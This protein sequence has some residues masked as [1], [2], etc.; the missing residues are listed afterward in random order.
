M[1]FSVF[2]LALSLASF[3]ELLS[4][5]S[6]EDVEGGRF[7]EWNKSDFRTGGKTLIGEGGG[8]TGNRFAI[9]RSD[10]DTERSAWIQRKLLPEGAIAVEVGGWYR[11]SP[12][13]K[14]ERYKGASLRV[15]WFN[16]ANGE[17]ALTQKFYPVS[18]AWRE[19]KDELFMAPAGAV[20]VELQVFHWLTPGETHW[21]DVSVKAIGKEDLGN[22]PERIK[23]VYG[24]DREPVFGTNL[25]YSPEHGEVVSMNPPPFRWL[26]IAGTQAYRLQICRKADF[27]DSSLI[28]R[29]DYPWLVEVPYEPLE[30]GEWHWRYGVEVDSLGCLWSKTR[31]FT[32][33]ADAKVWP[34]PKADKFQVSAARPRLF[35]THEG[36]PKLRERALNGNLKASAESLV[37][38]VQKYAGEELVAEPDFLPA[39]RDLRSQAYTAIFRATRPPM[40]KMQ[41]A[42]QAYLLT[43]DPVAG[44]E[45]K[46]RV[47]H[48]FG[49]DPKGSTNTFHNDEPA[50]WVMMRGCR[51]YDWTYEL[52][53][54]EER[55]KVE[56]SMT[57]RARDI[58]R[59]LRRKP[60]DNNP[61]ESHAGRQIGFLGEAAI[62][63]YHEVPDEAKEWLQ[64]I[65]RI[66]WG[67]YPAWGGEDGGWNEG[68]H[69]WSAYM[70]FALHFVLALRE[71]TGIDISR[72]PFFANT[73]YY[74][75]YQ[76]PPRSVIS[77]FGDGFQAGAMTSPWLEYYFGVLHDNPY[78]SWYADQYN[79]KGSSNAYSI[80]AVVLSG[81][82]VKPKPPR[83]IPQTK[84]FPSVGLVCSHTD[85]A[86]RSNDIALSFRSSPY[87]AVSHGHNDQNTFAIEA[88]GE[89][90]AIPTGHYNYYGSPHHDKWTRSTKA[91]CG[92]TFDGGVGQGRGWRAQGK[93]TRFFHNDDFDSFAG[94]ATAAYGGKL[95]LALREIV[96][97]RPG[98][99]VIKDTLRTKQPKC[100]EYWLH[101]KDKMEVDQEK[102]VVTIQRPKATMTADFLL[103]R[104]LT[105]KQTDLFDPPQTWSPDRKADDHQW[106]LQACA[107]AAYET[108]FLT[109]LQ[110]RKNGDASP[111]PSLKL[112][113]NDTIQGVEATYPDGSRTVV[114]F[115]RDQVKTGIYGK[116]AFDAQVQAVRFAPDGS[117]KAILA[118]E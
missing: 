92:I 83:D 20:R 63:L 112:L 33:P 8:H 111:K 52:Y 55:A 39:D 106:H 64:Y 51:A 71:A 32:V 9:C 100:F 60:F 101:A 108:T 104:K 3:G 35:V 58:Y 89:P 116:L 76:C 110:P 75:L 27:S 86:D 23:N 102:G 18:P 5:R 99:I 11:T 40:D 16:S 26:P 62:A 53:T 30:A 105:F 1:R 34:F 43:G 118:E 65:V 94:D 114:A 70:D 67:V 31:T 109:V 28:E 10:K 7:S 14:N 56:A 44:A 74:I 21:D 24:I 19:I 4:N 85:L 22:N 66:Y 88:F 54:P 41:Q 80:L 68:P 107:Y 79:V 72:K 97:V 46:R 115:K 91:K 96:H 81:K 12:E 47:L 29:V 95:E 113:E 38:R 37:A 59:M 93:I 69:Y 17:I 15:H 36:L 98:L 50:M 78:L 87:G 61:Y 77:P 48:F 82:E 103:P 117:I 73:G 49:W 84:Y 13:V 42:A 25:P 57:E 6:F 2:V 90:L 45:A